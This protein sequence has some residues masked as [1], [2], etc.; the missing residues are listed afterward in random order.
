MA[1]IEQ[2]E[3]E[4]HSGPKVRARRI[5]TRVDM[6]P[7][8]DLGFL[9]ITFFMLAT[10][11]TKPTAMSAFFPDNSTIETDPVKASRV[12]TL[13]LGAH[14]QV[15]YLDGVAAG[16]SKA[17]SS[18]KTTKYGF[19]LRNVIFASQKRVD[20]AHSYEGKGNDG[21]V[22]VIKPTMVSSYKNMVDVLD[23]MAITKS[24]RY[25]LVD[26]LTE[27]EKEV[28]GNRVLPEN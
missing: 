25:A 24:K 18:L 16:D 14:D 27:P 5:S 19:D 17:S 23:E 8:V 22:V 20:A 4:A 12:L 9:L 28:L 2:S 15:F 7:M 6:T 21:L 10:T 13:F 26:K 11:M 3:S 1:A